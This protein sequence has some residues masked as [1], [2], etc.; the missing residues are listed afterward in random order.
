MANHVSAEKRNRQRIVRTARNRA[1]KSEVRTYVKKVRLA[2]AAKDESSANEALCVAMSKL[3]KAARK[4]VIHRNKASRTI[5][6][7]STALHKMKTTA[8]TAV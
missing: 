6:R 1:V 8:Q 3:H 5:A 7:L 4:G 2:I